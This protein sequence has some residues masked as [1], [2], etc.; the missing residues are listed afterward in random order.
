MVQTIGKQNKMAAIRPTNW[1]QNF[2]TF[3]IP[4]FGIQATTVF[5]PTVERIHNVH[6]KSAPTLLCELILTHD[7]INIQH[8][9]V[10]PLACCLLASTWFLLAADADADAGELLPEVE[11]TFCA[12]VEVV[13]VVV[14]VDVV[15]VEFCWVM[16]V[17][18]S[19]D[20]VDDPDSSSVERDGGWSPDW[21][22]WK[23]NQD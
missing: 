19:Q 18:S 21:W 11:A 2:K 13:V 8:C 17:S 5:T 9:F 20:D 15:D 16:P 7:V 1:K 12:A 10:L 14:V 23:S 6:L 3:G 4:M 22:A